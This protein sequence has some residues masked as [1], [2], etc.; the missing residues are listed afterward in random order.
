MCVRVICICVLAVCYFYYCSVC[1]QCCLESDITY[2]DAF[3]H[4][5]RSTAYQL[6]SNRIKP[7]INNNYILYVIFCETSMRARGAFTYWNEE[8]LT[9]IEQCWLDV[10]ESIFR[11]PHV[12]VNVEGKNSEKNACTKVYLPLYRKIPEMPTQKLYSRDALCWF[13]ANEILKWKYYRAIRPLEKWREDET[14]NAGI[15]WRQLD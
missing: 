15:T 2:L 8:K 5:H 1:S 12:Y 9:S 13:I 4:H 14:L 11:D 3:A 6:K 10:F 7:T